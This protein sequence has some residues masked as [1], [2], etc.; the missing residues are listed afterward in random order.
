MS[1][2]SSAV[3]SCTVGVTGGDGGVLSVLSASSLSEEAAANDVGKPIMERVVVLEHRAWP[4]RDDDVNASDGSIICAARRV[5]RIIS[6]VIVDCTI[7]ATC[8]K[9]FATATCFVATA[10]D[11]PSKVAST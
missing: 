11:L 3:N 7:I 5:H 1:C 6:D 8:V 2:T 9:C 10:Q 4:P